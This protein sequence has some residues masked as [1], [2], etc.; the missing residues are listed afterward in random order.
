MLPFG[1]RVGKVG[2]QPR[3]EF[4]AWPA[5]IARLGVR[6]ECN[7]TAS[8]RGNA[9]QPGRDAE[10]YSLGCFPRP[11]RGVRFGG[12]C[13]AFAGTNSAGPGAFLVSGPVFVGVGVSQT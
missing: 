3:R 11:L 2:A 8:E 7:G 1:K 5:N 4:G 6:H 12:K 13:G 9:I 10:N